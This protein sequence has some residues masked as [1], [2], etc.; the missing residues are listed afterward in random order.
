MSIFI[1]WENLNQNWNEVDMLWE[2]VILIEEVKKIFR[3]GGQS[4]QD[5]IEGNP[6]KKITEKLG[7]DKTNKVIKIYCKVNEV[8]YDESREVINEL[9]VSVNDFERFLNY[10]PI[11]VKILS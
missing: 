6:W 4:L 2:E 7:R 11:S 5:Y 9:K 10:D 8:E 3:G 1:N